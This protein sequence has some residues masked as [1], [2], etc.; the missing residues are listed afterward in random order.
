MSSLRKLGKIFSSKLCS[1]Q[2]LFLVLNLLFCF[3]DSC[4]VR[5][6]ER[7]AAIRQFS[8]D[9]LPQQKSSSVDQVAK[10]RY[11]ENQVLNLNE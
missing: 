11:T 1:S 3:L 4:P 5:D 2:I 10:Q 7:K 9:H 6:S 8:L